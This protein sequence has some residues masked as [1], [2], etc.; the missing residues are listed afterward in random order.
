MGTW[1][2]GEYWIY[3]FKLK[4]VNTMQYLAILFLGQLVNWCLII[5]IKY[6]NNNNNENA[7][8]HLENPNT[9]SARQ[10]DVSM[11]TE[12]MVN[13]LAYFP[14]INEAS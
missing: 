2:R 9:A 4:N 3:S 11:H 5:L 1:K 13:Y 10:E 12:H 8:T 14:T 7:N 6:W